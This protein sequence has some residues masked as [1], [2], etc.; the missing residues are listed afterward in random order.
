MARPR[1]FTPEEAVDSAM[2]AFWRDGAQHVSY[3]QLVK[4]TGA[5]RHGLYQ[6]FGS[7]DR[8]LLSSLQH[9]EKAVLGDLMDEL[10]K[11][12]AA[13][14]ELKHFFHSI[15]KI[16]RYDSDSSGCL[17]CNTQLEIPDKGP[18]RSHIDSF[19]KRMRSVFQQCLDRA[20]QQGQI[21][22]DKDTSDLSHYLVGVVHSISANAQS[23]PS[24]DAYDSYVE[25][26]LSV[27][28]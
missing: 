20:Q 10:L 3:D 21:D 8:L 5:S 22:S 12:D 27:L 16:A 4:K 7:K 17:I 15:A 23:T 11:E 26:A 6:E 28:N 1:K 13:L 18:V 9:Y 2:H 14:Q 25:I 24:N 19:F